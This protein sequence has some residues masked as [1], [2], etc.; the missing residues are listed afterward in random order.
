MSRHDPTLK[1]KLSPHIHEQLPDFV[2]EESP[3]FSLFLKYYYEFLEAGEL[4]LSGE[5]VYVVEETI[6][7]NYILDEK[8]ERVVLEESTGKFVAGETIVGSI[9]NATAKV[10][11]DDY[12]DN[13]RLFITSQQRFITGETVTGQTSGA[14]TS[15]ISY[16][17]NPVQNIQQLLAFADVDNTVYD[18]LDKFRDSFMEA[19]P[20]TLAEGIEK[21]KLIKSVK[22]LYSAKGT[23]DGHKLFF[24]ILFNEESEITYPRDNLLRSSDGQWSTDKVIRVT[25]NGTSD[26]SK[27][28]GQFITGQTSGAKAIVTTVIKFREG[29]VLIAELNLDEQS[30]VGEFVEG[31]TLT[32]IDTE[33]D[34]EISATVKGIVTGAVI[35][36]S[37]AYYDVGD[38]VVI[39][40]GGN[41]AATA[42]IESIETGN[43]DAILI[44]NGGSGYSVGEELVYNNTDTQGDS[45]RA[46]VAVVGGGFLL[47]PDTDPDNFITED[48]SIILGNDPFDIGLETATN[49]TTYLV[50]ETDADNLLLE[51][52]SLILAEYDAEEYARAE[53]TTENLSGSL[54]NED[55]TR[56]LHEQSDIVHFQQEE[57]VGELD[58][59]V[60]E[61]GGQIIIEEETFNDL[62]VSSEIGE[63]TKIEIINKGNG[64][65]K[66][67]LVSMP[68]DTSGSGAELYAC[69]IS[70]PKIGHVGGISITNF[71]LNYTEVPDVIFNRNF[72]VKDISGAFNA[73]DDLTSHNGVVV[74]FDENRNILKINTSVTLNNDDVITTITGA[75]CVVSETGVAA[76]SITIGTIGTTV[77]D[78]ISDRGK[79]SDNSMK[80]QDSY[81]YQDYSY[82]VRVGES[83]N[84]WRNSIRRSVHP[85]GWNVFG[86]VSFA[87][88]VAAT[89]NIP[90]AGNVTDSGSPETFSPELAST[91]TNLFT[92]IFGRRLGTTT[93]STQ[94]VN[95]NVGVAS[96]S[97]LTDGQREVTLT[98]DVSVRMNIDRLN[99]SF[100][101]GPTLENVAKFGFAVHPV[102][103]SEPYPNSYDPGNRRIT[104]PSNFS[105]D[106]YTLA[107]I[108]YIGIRDLCLADGTIPS[109]AYT[110]RVNFMPPSEISIFRSALTNNFDNDFIKFDDGITRFDEFDGP[111]GLDIEGR[112]ATSYDEVGV[113][114][115]STTTFDVASGNEEDFHA[116]FDSVNPTSETMDT[117]EF[118]FDNAAPE[119]TNY[120]LFSDGVDGLT[121]DNT[122]TD[123]F[124]SQS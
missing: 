58:H 1:N 4:T 18:F 45:A 76:G 12:D 28:I 81:Y 9:S 7:K 98:S 90:S 112:Y 92:T 97:E 24:R 52:G 20:N 50:D 106:Q 14:S 26:F 100:T 56:L 93:D 121:F 64:Y 17:A 99:T 15:V 53:G 110:T 71:G 10:L 38:I 8:E 111:A 109:D 84:Q 101:L 35:T 79:I 118:T 108:G 68:S 41:N 116:T 33:L 65:I 11:V 102:D 25:E 75:T 124:D 16:R 103:T 115:D 34:L 19:I 87:S 96:P 70:F 31:E 47:E 29:N 91:F 122:N 117:N 69:S 82:V 42:R 48:G 5:N 49:S 89:I 21:R 61:T 62:G 60:L 119:T 107:Q 13:N 105:R 23:A 27:A 43:V 72:L 6:S 54:I 114:F 39:G 30:V 73:G 80:V 59:L 37:G 44:D 78:F 2:K 95:A 113:T 55:D 51:D 57:S 123:R 3:L 83:I 67:P 66:T 22:D 40:S 36:D 94:R 86:E 77:G 104:Q 63:I 120:N 46:K 32:T 74:D 88:Q 85:A